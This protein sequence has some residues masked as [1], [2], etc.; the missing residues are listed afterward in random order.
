MISD[1]KIQRI[2]RLQAEGQSVR[3]IARNV[4]VA[5]GTVYRYLANPMLK[6]NSPGSRCRKSKLQIFGNDELRDA[7]TK[8]GGNSRLI[9]QLL[10]EKAAEKQLPDFSVHESTIR[11][12]FKTRFPEF[13]PVPAP[14]PQYFHVEPGEQLQIDFVEAKFTFAGEESPRKV[15]LFEA[16]YSWSRK[17]FVRVCP[18]MTQNS[19]LMAI[20]ECLKTYGVPLSILCDNDRSLV[21]GRNNGKAVFNPAFKWLCQPLQIRISACKICHPQTKGRVERFGRFL[22]ENGLKWAAAHQ[23]RIRDHHDL[24]RELQEWERTFASTRT[25]TIDDGTKGVVKDFYE[26][27]K[28]YLRFPEDIKEVFAVESRSVASTANGC[29][30]LYGNKIALGYHCANR[31]FSVSICVDGRYLVSDLNGKTVHQGTIPQADLH[32]YRWDDGPRK[33]KDPSAKHGSKAST[34]AANED[35]VLRQLS[36]AT[37]A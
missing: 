21:V 23:A 10:K 19:W 20:A 11:R 32:N 34:T 16:V 35:P 7:Y 33:R 2:L 14:E 22:Q 27:E 29:I 31:E 28:R 25:V 36:D 9:L 13:S 5:P 3:E 6:Q 24:N 30:C 18:D 4:E 1:Q 15:Y 37:G 17:G 8:A 26:R 12:F